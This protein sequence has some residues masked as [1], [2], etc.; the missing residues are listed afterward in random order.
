MTWFKPLCYP[1]VLCDSVVSITFINHRDAET[2]SCTE[3][4]AT[5]ES[6]FDGNYKALAVR[7][8]PPKV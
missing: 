7:I 8:A 2:Q 4:G 3:K 5:T 6:K 1:R